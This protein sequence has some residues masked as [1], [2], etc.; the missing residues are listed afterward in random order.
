MKKTMILTCL[1]AGALCACAQEKLQISGNV[2]ETLN[3]KYVYLLNMDRG[4]TPIDS[5]L[6]NGGKVALKT[7]FG[8]NK[9]AIMAI[10]RKN[11][12]YFPVYLDNTNITFDATGDTWTYTGSQTNNLLN[13]YDQKKAP[14]EKEMAQINADYMEAKKKGEI[15]KETRNEIYKRANDAEAKQQNLL[16]SII[17][18]NTNN[19]ASAFLLAQAY[20]NMEP[21][22]LQELVS[23]QGSFR[24]TPQFKMVQQYAESLKKSMPGTDFT[25][26]E[27]EDPNG[28]KHSTKEF[29]G[30]GKYVLVDF[31]A[32]WCGPCRA[33]MPSV[34]KLYDQYKDKGFDVLGVSFDNQK[35]A[36][37]KAIDQ[38]GLKWNHISDL[39]GWQCA[40]AGIYGI[41]GIPFMLLVG[42]DGKIVARNLHGEALQ[43]K[44]AEL[45]K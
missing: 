35:D 16:T 25:H 30:N 26:F 15:P 21:E 14:I 45:I 8:Q 12:M 22:T 43:K 44:V 39:K 36:W 24:D 3:G 5:A 32:S 31:W 9:F 19:V 4:N 29:I 34:K 13:E 10:E 11:G 27:M 17:K 40:A 37:V 1:C 7:A 20:N 2:P 42:P 23:L 18:A 41:R 28:V 38:L 33:A 6:V